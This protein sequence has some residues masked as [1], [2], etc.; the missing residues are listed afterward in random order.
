MLQPFAE[1]IYVTKPYLP[2]L[3]TFKA[4]LE[5]IWDTAWLTNGG[6]LLQ[7]FTRA[8]VEYFDTPNLSLFANGTWALQIALRGMQLQG[9]VITTP[10]TFPATAHALCWSNLKPVFVDIEPHHYGL[11]PAAVEAAITPDTSA[12]LAVH[13]YGYPCNLQALAEIARRHHLYLIYDAAHAFGVT[14]GGRSL[15]L[16]GDVSMLS[17]HATKLF[18]SIEGG[19]LVYAD[20]RWQKPFN[21]LKNFGFSS[22]TEVVQTGTNAKMNEFQALMGSLLLPEIDH[23]IATRARLTRLY[24]ER[25]AK[26]PGISLPPPT[27]PEVADNYAYLTVEIDREQGGLSRDELYERLKTFNVYTRR[28]FYPLLTDFPCYSEA[29]VPHELPV[30]TRAAERI[31]TLPLYHDLTTE[32]VLRLCDIISLLMSGSAR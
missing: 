30:A 31:L 25:L 22:E 14:V 16:Y 21:Q 29:R 15:A 27:A 11:D 2:P 23:L 19:L 3:A 12:I 18:H 32:Q 13:V 6:P 24:R 28:Y 9:E 17:L 8:L 4:A 1:P 20:T 7:R 10:Y 26:I 5:E